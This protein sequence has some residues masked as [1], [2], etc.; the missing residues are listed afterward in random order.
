MC[1]KLG[2]ARR[3]GDR[4]TTGTSRRETENEYERR[5]NCPTFCS[6]PHNR[7]GTGLGSLFPS[8]WLRSPYIS[9][10]YRDTFYSIYT[11]AT[12]QNPTQSRR[13]KAETGRR[14]GN[15]AQQRSLP[16]FLRGW[17]LKRAPSPASA[18]PVACAP[19]PSKVSQHTWWRAEANVRRGE[20]S[21]R[22]VVEVGDG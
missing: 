7:G 20:S 3:P 22:G 10:S 16:T 6:N 14:R 2:H 17:R 5:A 1:E 9:S 19:T 13:L 18:A 8:P 21:R 11:R 4:R 15:S 12:Q